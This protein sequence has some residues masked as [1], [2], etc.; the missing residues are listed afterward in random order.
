[1]RGVPALGDDVLEFLIGLVNQA[2]HHGAFLRRDVAGRAVAAEHVLE[3]AAFV[4]HRRDADLVHQAAII[5]AVHD[6]ADA[7]GDGQVVGDNPAAA[8]G[9]I[10]AAGRREAAH[11]ADDGL[12]L[13]AGLA[14]VV[15][16]VRL[17]RS[18]GV[19]N[20]IRRQ[21]FAAGGIHFQDD[22]LHA[23]VVAGAV[24]LGLDHVHHVVA[25]AVKLVAGDDAVHG[26][27]GDFVLRPVVFQNKFVQLWAGLA[28][29]SERLGVETVVK[30]QHVADELGEIAK[31]AE[32]QQHQQN[33]GKNHPAAALGR[34][35]RRRDDRRRR[36]RRNRRY[37]HSARNL[38]QTGRGGKRGWDGLQPVLILILFLIVII[39]FSRL[40]LGL[41]LRW[42][43]CLSRWKIDTAARRL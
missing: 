33:D 18:D 6:D 22:G 23:L 10:I 36:R 43:R 38:A 35:R 4:G 24:E 20:L 2:L 31:Q 14:V 3:L 8:G 34:Q 15:G 9:N 11:R 19:V 17:K 39:V 42:G 25:A 12:A 28:G 32:G 26:D 30:R 41:R 16:L 37:F 7:A 29:G 5:P 27:D 21:H 1:M 13:A 40:R